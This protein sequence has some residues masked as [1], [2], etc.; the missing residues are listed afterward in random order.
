VQAW[1]RYP[2]HTYTW[3]LTFLSWC[4]LGNDTPNT[5]IHDHSLSWLGT[6]LV[7]I[8]PTHIYMTKP[9]KWVV[10]YMC[11]G[12][13]VT[14]PAPTQ[15]SEWSCICVLGVSFPSLHQ[16]RKVSGHVYVCWGYRYQACTSP[17]KC[18]VMCMCVGGIVS[19][20]LPSQESKWYP[21]HTYTWPLTFLGW[22]RLGN[23]TPNTHIHDHSLSWV[24][25]GTSINSK[26]NNYRYGSLNIMA[27]SL[28]S[29]VDLENVE[30]LYIIFCVS[31]LLCITVLEIKSV[32]PVHNKIC[33][34]KEFRFNVITTSFVIILCSTFFYFAMTQ[35]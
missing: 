8:P 4:R 17:G 24:G 14:K 3:P 26:R 29:K 15:E 5:H 9:G 19:K 16:P 28:I 32:V 34:N 22:C 12:G 35:L 10:M 33:G 30:A 31:K 21:Q 11:V 2:Q 13:I 7:T 20:P 6:D 23:D 18:V 27:F 25:A 1:K